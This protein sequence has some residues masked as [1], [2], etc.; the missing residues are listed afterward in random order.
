MA[1]KLYKKSLFVLALG[2]FTLAS[3]QR[4]PN[5]TGNE[6]APQMYRSV[7]YEPL[8]EYGGVKNKFNPHGMNMRLPVQGTVM[9]RLNY[10]AKGDTSDLMIYNIHKDSIEI[11]ERTLSNPFLKNDTTLAEGKILYGNVC[12]PCHGENGKGD[13]T[14]AKLYKGVPNYSAGAYKTMNDGHIFHVITNGKGRMWP[15]GSQLSPEERWK[16]VLYVHELQQQ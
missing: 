14:V 9:R 2:V 1:V 10:A 4:D 12:Q 3:C 8:R 11:A 7:P 6:Y 16:I 15:H 5:D 13:G